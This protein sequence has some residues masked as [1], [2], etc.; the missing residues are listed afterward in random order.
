MNGLDLL[1]G[2]LLGQN[3]L[4]VDT[5]TNFNSNT[6]SNLKAEIAR[7]N[8]S[9]IDNII[10][11]YQST[12]QI[13]KAFEYYGLAFKKFPNN[14]NYIEQFIKVINPS[15]NNLDLVIEYL[16]KG[17]ETSNTECMVRC[18]NLCLNTGRYNEMKRYL[19]M[20][21]A[22]ERTDAL[23]TLIEYYLEHEKNNKQEYL[24]NLIKLL[25]VYEKLDI[26][27]VKIYPNPNAQRFQK[28]KLALVE[29]FIERNDL[30]NIIVCHQVGITQNHVQSYLD[31]I[32]H[33]L[34]VTNEFESAKNLVKS[35]YKT[36]EQVDFIKNVI[37]I[38][39]N[40]DSKYNMFELLCMIGAW[41]G[42]IFSMQKLAEKS[43]EKKKYQLAISSYIGL[44]IYTNISSS[45]IGE[46]RIAILDI[47]TKIKLECQNPKLE[48]TVLKTNINNYL[49][50]DFPP[51]HINLFREINNILDINI[52]IL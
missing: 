13:L 28:Y 10:N 21:I 39:I 16:S 45:V 22:F 36:N 4:P 32:E 9:Y 30:P 29:F 40:D 24:Q 46:S 25:R 18:G 38:Y 37:G 19:N 7:G 6:E 3:S 49:Q 27:N 34:Y 15:I 17:F 31:L 5:G 44:I 33:Y 2:I 51:T 23:I 42:N 47:I 20:A 41:V 52:Q 11:Y 8:Y 12:G 43:I 50:N 35:M 26:S 14:P 1:C 48:L